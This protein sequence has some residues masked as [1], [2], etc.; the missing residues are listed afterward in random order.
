MPKLPVLKPREVVRLLMGQ[1]SWR[2]DSVVRTSS[3]D[4]PMAGPPLSRSTREETSPP[5][6]AGDCK[7][8]RNVS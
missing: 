6:T 3:F 5:R 4:T 7:G 1:D 2:S 8:Y